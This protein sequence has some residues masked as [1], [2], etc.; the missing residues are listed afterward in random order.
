M[1]IPRDNELLE[2]LLSCFPNVSQLEMNNVRWDNLRPEV[3]DHFLTQFKSM[4]LVSMCDVKFH[5][6][7]DLLHLLHGFPHLRTLHLRRVQWDTEAEWTCPSNHVMR[8]A[9]RTVPE[10]RELML[11]EAPSSSSFLSGLFAGGNITCDRELRRLGLDWGDGHEDDLSILN[12]LVRASRSLYTLELDLSW[13]GESNNVFIDEC[14]IPFT[15]ILLNAVPLIP[16]D[17]SCNPNLRGIW[18]DGL[19]LDSP[20]SPTSLKTSWLPSLISSIIS[21]NVIQIVLYIFLGN[22]DGV[23]LLDLERIDGTLSGPRFAQ[24]QHLGFI[25]TI[26]PHPDWSLPSRPDVQRII[27]K[28]MP[29]AHERGILKFQTGDLLRTV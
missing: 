27:K 20:S 10:L 28:R 5:S 25:V 6:L 13:H 19:L 16:L 2:P 15:T 24:L 21:P 7:D 1:P 8:V 17:L 4:T 22:T 12:N 29:K 18:L 9:S 23:K 26:L 11:Y 14:Y 3:R